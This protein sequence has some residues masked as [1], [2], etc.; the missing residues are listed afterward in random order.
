MII[1]KVFW[2]G[3]CHH[4]FIGIV[5]VLVYLGLEAIYEYEWGEKIFKTIRYICVII[6]FVSWCLITSVLIDSEKIN[7]DSWTQQYISQKQLIEDSLNNEKLSGLERLELVKQA[8]ELN[9]ELIDK[10]IKCVKWYNFTM[11]DDVLK[12]ELVS[13]N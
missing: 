4:F 6:C 1:W 13:L 12:L 10:Q 3:L 9:A 8:N 5:L 7:N 2:Q 11:D